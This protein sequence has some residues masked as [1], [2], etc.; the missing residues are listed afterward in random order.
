M[1]EPEKSKI[2]E[3]YKEVAPIGLGTGAASAIVR[4]GKKLVIDLIVDS[5]D[6]TAKDK[7]T[8]KSTLI[9]LFDS[10]VGDILFS[11]ALAE[12]IG[13]VSLLSRFIKEEHIEL[14][15]TC[16]RMNASMK[17]GELATSLLISGGG[18]LINKLKGKVEQ[19]S[20]TADTLVSIIPETVSA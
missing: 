2:L 12:L 13:H 1:G 15:Q 9:S 20:K 8:Y 17:T 4:E 14:L 18:E 5:S 3:K 6:K 16:F 7:K 10:P 11:A 19:L